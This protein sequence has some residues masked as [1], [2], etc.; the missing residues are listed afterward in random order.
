[1]RLRPVNLNAEE[2]KRVGAMI[3]QERLKEVLDYGPET[4]VFVWLQ[5]RGRRAVGQIADSPTS[6][7][8]TRIHVDGRTYMAHRLAFLYMTG[9]FPPEEI[10]HINGVR[11]DNRWE[12]L[13]AVSPM[14]NKR[15]SRMHDRNKTGVV[16][17]CRRSQDGCF[18]VNFI[19]NHGK[20]HQVTRK[21]FFEAVCIRKSFENRAGTYH[22]NH[23]RVV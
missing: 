16:G 1:M 9:E 21:D 2:P 17:V 11:S 22:A 6:Y 20:R 12:N 7:G 10:D 19:D 3:T 15:N 23:G 8:Y 18:A 4:G 13:R 14:I 5:K